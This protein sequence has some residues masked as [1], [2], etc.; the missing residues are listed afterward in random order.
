MYLDYNVYDNKPRHIHVPKIFFLSFLLPFYPLPARK[1]DGSTDTTNGER[2]ARQG[3]DDGW[4]DVKPG[5][6]FHFS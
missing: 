4:G 6:F 3:R 2:G 1:G 5:T